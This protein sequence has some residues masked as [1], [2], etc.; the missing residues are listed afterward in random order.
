MARRGK[1]TPK[2]EPFK[3]ALDAVEIL[4]KHTVAVMVKPQF[5]AEQLAEMVFKPNAL[6]PLRAAYP[7]FDAD[8][9]YGS[10][11]YLIDVGLP[12]GVKTYVEINADQA[13]FARPA[14]HCIR[15][16]ADEP[17]LREMFAQAYDVQ[18]SWL[19]VKHVVQWF[20][21]NASLATTRRIWPVIDILAGA[22]NEPPC[23]GVPHTKL[24]IAGMLPLIRSTGVT[25]AASA[26]LPPKPVNENWHFQFGIDD[27]EYPFRD[28][29]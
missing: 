7:Y 19:L 20:S 23:G 18:V 1:R 22:N 17:E 29:E 10:G 5:T 8:R 26:L 13:R 28:P 24:P 16:V 9:Y 4:R 21:E 25:V 14:A 27:L 11:E 3:R 15:S 6:A 2:D 12:N